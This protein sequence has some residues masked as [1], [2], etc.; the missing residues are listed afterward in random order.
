M[1]IQKKSFCKCNGKR[2]YFND[3][4]KQG[5][6]EE[7]NQRKE[8]TAESSTKYKEHGVQGVLCP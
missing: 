2:G 4:G 3:L 6:D 5:L 1:E 8:E 7:E